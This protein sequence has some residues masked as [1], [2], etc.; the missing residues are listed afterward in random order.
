MIAIRL[1]RAFT[2]KSEIL[3]VNGC[4][5]GWS[6]QLLYDMRAVNTKNMYA[7][8]VPDE[9]FLHINS[10]YPNDINE[11]EQ[12]FIEN[13]KKGGTAAF[14]LEAVGQDSGALP[15]TREFHQR[16]RELC[17]KYGALLIYDEVVTGFRLGI[18][19]AQSYFG[20]KPDL[21]MFGKTITGGFP[22]SGAIGG[23][24]D[25][26]SCLSSGVANASTHVLVG[27]TLSANPVSCVAGYTAICEMERTN[28]HEKLKKASDDFTREVAKLADKYDVP[29]AIFN[30][31]SILHIDLT[32]LQHCT[33]HL[34]DNEIL[35]NLHDIIENATQLTKEFAMALAAEGLIVAA[36]NKM[37]INLQTIPV[38]DEALEMFE[39]VFANYQ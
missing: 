32:G 24:R 36:G 27:G 9:C 1:A 17:D 4:Y 21:T 11:M 33:S 19:G 22:S 26:M 38:L 39:R 3:K 14:I 12:R 35:G 15:L 2:G 28:A 25:V 18:G 31:D 7:S 8:G 16:A 10:V 20:I 29:A 6:D 23:R 34:N 5:H 13:E 30:Q 37:F